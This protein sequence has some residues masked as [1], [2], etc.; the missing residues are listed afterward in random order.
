[1]NTFCQTPHE[2]TQHVLQCPNITVKIEWDEQLNN[3]SQ[4]M[5]ENHGKPIMIQ[6]II[7]R[8]RTWQQHAPILPNNAITPLL[9]HAITHQT[10]IGWQNLLEGFLTK[11]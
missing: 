3:L 11:E 1:M 6:Q 10:R 7:G 9:R 2:D 5:T 8:L 4:W